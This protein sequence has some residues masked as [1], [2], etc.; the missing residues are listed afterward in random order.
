MSLC[1]L[2]LE[3][4]CDTDHA[5]LP[6]G[7]GL[8]DDPDD[9]AAP[10]RPSADVVPSQQLLALLNEQL[11]DNPVQ[12]LG[13]VEYGVVIDVDDPANPSASAYAAKHLRI[14]GRVPTTREANLNPGIT[15]LDAAVMGVGLTVPQCR[16]ADVDQPSP[17]GCVPGE[18]LSGDTVTLFPVETDNTRETYTTPTL[19]GGSETLTESI[20]YQWLAAQ[21]S[22]SDETTGGG[23]DLLGNQSLLGTEWRAP[24]THVPL[25]VPVWM[26]Q[27]DERYGTNVWETCLRVLPQ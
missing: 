8:I 21:G 23:H 1:L 13:G 20:T 6:L 11:K 24:R 25:D 22:F 17:F 19:T 18:L 15:Y 27:R 7:S 4:R 26:V 14:A 3:D 9:S 12:A 16:C 5:V 2:T 10:Q